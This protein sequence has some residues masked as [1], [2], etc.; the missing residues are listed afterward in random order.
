MLDMRYEL[1]GIIDKYKGTVVEKMKDPEVFTE[2]EGDMHT[3]FIHRCSKGDIEAKR[4][5]MNKVKNHLMNLVEKQDKMKLRNIVIEHFTKIKNKEYEV[6]DLDKIDFYNEEALISYYQ[7]MEDYASEFQKK[8]FSREPEQVDE[9][10]V[11]A[12]EI[13]KIEYGLSYIEEL[14][15]MRIN[16]I[17][18]HGSDK[19]RVE[20]NKG[21]WY[22]VKDYR[23]ETEVEVRLIAERLY[24]Q[25][26][27]GQ[28]TDEDCEKEGRLL[29]GARLT[30]TLAP[31]SDINC[32][33]IKKFDSITVSK[34]MMLEN[35]TVTEEMLSDL[36]ILAKGRANA[37]ICGGVNTGKSTFAKIYVGLFPKHYKVGLVDSGK[38]T[39]LKELYPDRDIRTLYETDKY[40][41]NYQF[42]KM[43]RMG[44]HIICIGEARSFEVEQMLKSMTRGN[45]GSFCTLHITDPEAVPN[46]IAQMCLE[47]GI[48]QDVNVLRERVAEAVD[49][50]IRI[51]HFEDS[52]KRRVDYIGELVVRYDNPIRPF[53]IKPLYEWD[54]ELEMV[55]RVKNYEPSKTLL[56]KLKYYGCSKQEI[57]QLKRT[58]DTD[59][60]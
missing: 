30:I 5:V 29:N 45:S 27:N 49:I 24:S 13:Y 56:E 9:I 17:E 57:E 28:I 60:T 59:V 34:G 11:L 20:T 41:L 23:F 12:Y 7:L 19:I 25:D 51:R 40:D 46:A 43:L 6:I 8:F 52:G 50:V 14:L 37:V 26:G 42:S 21:I 2:Q 38:D 4:Y 47:S 53:E 44:R 1:K 10:E 35:G 48:Q 36:S 54:D 55:V 3:D 39:D 32:I 31:G 58:D 15:Y 22:T 16:N 33:F 18:V